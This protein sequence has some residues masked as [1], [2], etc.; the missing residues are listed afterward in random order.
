MKHE[1]WRHYPL[2]DK[3]ALV[4]RLLERGVAGDIARPRAASP[5]AAVLPAARWR[6]RH[7]PP[8]R[9]PKR[10]SKRSQSGE[11]IP[12]PYAAPAS[13]DSSGLWHATRTSRHHDLLPKE[14]KRGRS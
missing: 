13:A 1:I 5:A 14:Q 7:T 2:E 10:R 9:R 8:A 12:L 6:S 4:E 3:V 11:T